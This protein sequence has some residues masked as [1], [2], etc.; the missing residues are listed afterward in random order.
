MLWLADLRQTARQYPEFGEELA[1]R[2]AALLGVGV[3]ALVRRIVPAE[4]R[5]QVEEEA[6]EAV[7]RCVADE[8]P[9]AVTVALETELAVRSEL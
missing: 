3:E 9:A 1:E 4:V 7:A 8:L 6:R 2:G 5:Q